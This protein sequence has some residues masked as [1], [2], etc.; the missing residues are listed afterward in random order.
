MG[1]SV[2]TFLF[3]LVFFSFSLSG[4][5]YFSATKEMKAA[6]QL[7]SE[8]KAAGGATQVPYEYCSAEKFLENAK[9]EA[10]Q[11][12]WKHARDFA[13]RSK[14]AADAGLAQVKKK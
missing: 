1:K 14:S 11:S 6:E 9:L 4:C 10:D 8:L 7:I 12:D 5:Y 13:S 2:W 3:I